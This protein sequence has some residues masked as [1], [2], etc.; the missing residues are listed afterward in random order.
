M[1]TKPGDRIA[2]YAMRCTQPNEPCFKDLS[3]ETCW[4]AAALCALKAG[5][6]S[7]QQFSDICNLDRSWPTA[8][9]P[10][11]FPVIAGPEEMMRVPRG[12]FLGFFDIGDGLAQLIHAMVAVGH[13]KAAGNKSACI[14]T[15]APVGWEILDLA[16]GL[17]WVSDE[18]FF[19]AV[20]TGH[21]GMRPVQVRYRAF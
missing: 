7:H 5:A 16:N 13:G 6:I 17:R 3:A 10:L 19:N 18:N 4:V 20:P 8:F 1:N 2:D 12:S 9:V 21:T 14:G 15:G 11:D